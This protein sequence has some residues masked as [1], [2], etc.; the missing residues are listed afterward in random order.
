MIPVANLLVFG[1]CGLVLAPAWRIWPNAVGRLAAYLLWGLA[2]LELLLEFY[3]DSTPSH[4]SSWLA[5]S[6]P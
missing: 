5:G 3:R 1:S 6:P 2:S 4:T